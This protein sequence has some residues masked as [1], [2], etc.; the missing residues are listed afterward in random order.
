MNEAVD[1]KR[2]GVWFLQN[3]LLKSF[4]QVAKDRALDITKFNDAVKGIVSNHVE[5]VGKQETC[6][7][8]EI[9]F[10][11]R[12][13]KKI[14]SVCQQKFHKSCLQSDQ[15]LC[16]GA[17]SSGLQPGQSGSQ[18]VI[19]QPQPSV[20]TPPPQNASPPSLSKAYPSQSILFIPVTAPTKPSNIYSSCTPCNCN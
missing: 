15:H 17:G 2:A 12:S 14:C 19:S 9:P 6:H 3:F 13:L 16:L 4:S 1:K 18:V 20:P 11:G 10:T 8:C 7:V 5:K